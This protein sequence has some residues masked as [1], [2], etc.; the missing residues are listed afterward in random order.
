MADLEHACAR[1]CV[2]VQEKRFSWMTCKT[3]NTC[4]GK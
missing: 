4:H 1:P 3:T 2:P